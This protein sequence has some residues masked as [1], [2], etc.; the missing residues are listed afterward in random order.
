MMIDKRLIGTVKEAPK[1]IAGNVACQWVGL[2]ANVAA[3]LSVAKLLNAALA[4]T[5]TAGGLGLTALT[6]AGA[7]LVRFLCAGAAARMS[8]R[9][10]SRVKKVLRDRLYEKLLGLGPSYTEQVS[11]SEVVQVST[12]G[13]D[14]LETYFGRYLPQL[15]YSLLAP[16][17]LFIVLAPVYLPATAALLC[18]V[19]LIPASIVAVQKVAKRLLGKYWSA[20]TGL[21]D[22]FLENIQGLTT[23]KIY[24]ADE[25]RHQ[26]MNRQAELFRKIT[27]RVLTMQLSSVTIM[28]LVAFG[29]AALGVI[30]SVNGL[31]AGALSLS[32]AVAVI[33][34]SAEFFIP[35]R[36]LGSYFHI[37]MNGMAASEKIFRILDLD[38][39]PAGRKEPAP[40]EAPIRFEDVSFSYDGERTV[41]GGVSFTVPPRGFVSIAGVSGSGKSTIAGLLLGEN[42]GYSGSIRLGETE[43]SEISTGG[44]MGRITRVAHDSYLFGGTVA[45]NLRM[46]KPNATE[47]EMN[48]VLRAVNLHGFLQ[49]Q[50]GLDT[51]LT[52]QGG[53]LS[54]GQRQRLALARALLRES[55]VYVFDEATSNIDAESEAD[56]M[57]AIRA[58]ARTKTVLLISHRL[59]NLVESDLICMVEGG[60]IAEQGDHETLMKKNG[61]YA[62]LYR[63]QQALEHYAEGGKAPC[64]EAV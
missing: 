50:R 44:L 9:A 38:E 4:G 49:T 19:P 26:E 10:S 46:G 39:P 17:T 45:E 34:L 14:Q 29:G 52:E 53:N 21:G 28:D 30:L 62:R 32:G 6:V 25:A 20:Y 60:R 40:G 56:C 12:E 35:L 54:G 31:Q 64:E 55:D 5:W 42:R 7:V 36:L 1:Y 22:C 33:L 57:A 23:L 47:A 3:V 63:E 13:V 48:A 41:L 2:L 37:A 8:Y 11:T 43:L 51:V 24:K 58:L 15:F 16:V 59:A 61:P 18:C 27:M